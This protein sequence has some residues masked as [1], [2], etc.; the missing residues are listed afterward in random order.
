[1]E[2]HYPEEFGPPR[3][4]PDWRVNDEGTDFTLPDSS[5][6]IDQSC[7]PAT[8]TATVEPHA[9][10]IATESSESGPAPVPA[11][12][13]IPPLANAFWQSVLFGNPDALI[14]SSEVTRALQLVSSQ[15][16]VPIAN[17]EIIGSMRAGQLRKLLRDRFG[18][19]AAE[20]TTATL[21]RAAPAS[22]G[23]PQP[24]EDQSPCKLGVAECPRSMPAWRREF[25]SEV[26]DEQQLLESFGGWCG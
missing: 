12:P 11:P 7:M 15:L 9:P 14:P 4:Q 21:W 16:G 17:G 8:Q 23:A 3:N 20:Q 5:S 19:M 6:D 1:L 2:E 25:Y 18:P 13:P 26:S 24:A 22:P 10:A